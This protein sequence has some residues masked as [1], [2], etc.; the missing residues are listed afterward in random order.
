MHGVRPRGNSHISA[1]A[2]PVGTSNA[3]FTG[4]MVAFAHWSPAYMDRSGRE[5]LNLVENGPQGGGAVPWRPECSGLD[6]P[7]HRRGHAP[8]GRIWSCPRPGSEFRGRA[9][10]NR[11]DTNAVRQGP[12]RIADYGSYPKRISNLLYIG[13]SLLSLFPFC[14][15]RPLQVSAT[16]T[17]SPCFKYRSISS[18]LHDKN[19]IRRHS[20]NDLSNRLLTIP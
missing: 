6:F 9:A 12:E 4:V 17:A 19:R 16:N 7:P 11:P 1:A 13:I 18:R 15:I 8:V 3:G 5:P 14:V 2:T 10:T 20:R